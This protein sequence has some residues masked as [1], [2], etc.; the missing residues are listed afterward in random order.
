MGIELGLTSVLR[1]FALVAVGMG[2]AAL[3]AGCG[4]SIAP[5]GASPDGGSEAGDDAS[6]LDGPGPGFDVEVPDGGVVL[7][8]AGLPVCDQGV[9]PSPSTVSGFAP[10]WI[11]P[12]GAHQGVCTP[13]MLTSY[14]QQC[15]D[16]SGAQNC[17]TFA[18][19]PASQACMTCLNS[20]FT[21]GVWGPLVVSAGEVETNTAG[22]IAL[23][24]PGAMSCAQAIE[25]QDE[26]IH[27]SCDAVCAAGG[28][29]SS[30]DSWVTCSA[31][32]NGCGCEPY[33]QAA[34]CVKSLAGA[35][36]PAAPCLVGQTF[37]DFFY[38]V[39]AVF[40]GM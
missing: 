2:M 23:L 25:A 29:P 21:D 11:P 14:Y 9:C 22:C 34:Q 6:L 16:P 27:A 19:D 33:F 18:M 15:L 13:A 26:C 3:A 4:G 31:A 8:E 39:S 5:T 40:C 17:A 7:N 10:T 24:D 36:S 32:A 37:Q 38:S 12:T 1:F 35:K 20:D 28:D 30:F